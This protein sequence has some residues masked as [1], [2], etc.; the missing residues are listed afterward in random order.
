MPAEGTRSAEVCTLDGWSRSEQR[1]S[2]TPQ[3]SSLSSHHV[4]DQQRIYVY[5]SGFQDVAGVQV[6]DD[7]AADVIV[8]GD[9]TITLTLPHL[10]AGSTNWVIVHNGDGTA[11]PCEGD[12]QLVTVQA[13]EDAPPAALRIDAV[14]PDTVALG[15]SDPYWITGAGLSQVHAVTLGDSACQFESY[16]D[17][18]LMFTTPEQ[19]RNVADGGTAVLTV[20]ANEQTAT[21]SVTGSAGQATSVPDDPAPPALTGVSP[22]ELNAAGGQI[23]VQGLHLGHVV[24]VSVGPVSCVV[25]AVQA[26]T[27]TATVPSLADYVGQTLQV[28]VTDDAHASGETDILITVTGS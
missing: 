20:I 26:E 11:S 9:S 12:A 17:T 6:G 23:A 4:T 7:W 15:R 25:D 21:A 13:I 27:V 3:I 22:T 28:M 10:A 8:D 19:L 2:V 14:T 18:R 5:G 24:T 1:F 16:D